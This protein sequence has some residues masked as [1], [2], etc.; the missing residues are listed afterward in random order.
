VRE[1]AG[2][3][4]FIMKI[5]HF[6]SAVDHHRIHQAIR[7]AEEGTSGTIVL[8]ISHRNVKDSL[9]AANH[10]FQKL[11]LEATK[12]QN[13]LLIFLAPKS[14]KFAVVGGAALHDKMGQSWWNDL[15]ALLA[16]HFKESRYTD[17]L[18]DI[19]EQAGSALKTHFPDNATDRT[20]HR[21]IVEE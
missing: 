17:G 10:E 15:V 21:D 18:L 4:V 6:L 12:G 3:P 5:K 1:E 19:I 7:S 11:R 16:G 14:K 9:A 8:F 13:S 20:G 2:K